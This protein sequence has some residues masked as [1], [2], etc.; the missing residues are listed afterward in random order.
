MRNAALK[1]DPK[2]NA[3]LAF[4]DLREGE[5]ISSL[6]HI[7]ALVADVLEQ[8]AKAA[9][10]EVLT[11]TKLTGHNDFIPGKRGISL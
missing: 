5:P 11:R 4:G 3:L 1:L 8:V 6:N 7:C 2:D 9:N 10:G